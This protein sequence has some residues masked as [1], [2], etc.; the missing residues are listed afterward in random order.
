MLSRPDVLAAAA[1]C[2][3]T[4]EAAS[5]PSRRKLKGSGIAASQPKPSSDGP[6][7]RRAPSGPARPAWPRLAWQPW[8]WRS[9][10][11]APPTICGSTG[12]GAGRTRCWTGPG[13]WA[14]WF[15]P[16]RRSRRARA[17]ASRPADPRRAATASETASWPGPWRR[18]VSRRPSWPP[19]WRGSARAGR[20]GRRR[21]ARRGAARH[22]PWS[23][24]CAG[25]RPP[26]RG[27]RRPTA[28][29]RAAPR[30]RRRRRPSHGRSRA[31]RRPSRPRRADGRARRRT[32]AWPLRAT[33]GAGG[34]C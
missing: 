11:A 5:S 12:N 17:D 34:G 22:T 29:C 9:A 32:V 1:R 26:G 33:T 14:G 30:A 7:G 16:T 4:S 18:P 15:R 25:S 13:P 27:G 6:R 8:P 21:R 19:A 23:S 31:A 24:R 3:S 10:A 28:A 20:G 2:L